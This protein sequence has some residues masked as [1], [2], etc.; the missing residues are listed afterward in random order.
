MSRSWPR[1]TCETWTPPRRPM[2][3]LTEAPESMRRFFRRTVRPTAWKIAPSLGWFEG[4]IETPI[5]LDLVWSIG[6]DGLSRAQPFLLRSFT[7]QLFCLHSACLL[8]AVR[9][10]SGIFGR[11]VGP[12]SI[13]EG[14]AMSGSTTGR[15]PFRFAAG[16]AHHPCLAYG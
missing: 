7:R 4:S 3:G 6:S 11:Q 14:L 8:G 10:T 13:S 9:L 16:E 5:L 2:E 1:A 12:C 15:T